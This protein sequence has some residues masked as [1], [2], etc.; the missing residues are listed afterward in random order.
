MSEYQVNPQWLRYTHKDE[1]YL[2]AQINDNYGI[3]AEGQTSLLP[4]IP[5][6]CMEIELAPDTCLQAI[7]DAWNNVNGASRH[8]LRVHERELA[9]VLDALARENDDDR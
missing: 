5:V 9:D 2:L 3:H 7:T 4:L 8:E 6:E 1:G